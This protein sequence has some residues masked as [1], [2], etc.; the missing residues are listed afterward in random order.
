MIETFYL[1]FLVSFSNKNR[2]WAS[3]K[4]SSW[5]YLF[6]IF[7]VANQKGKSNNHLINQQ[8]FDISMWFF[9]IILS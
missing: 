2:K 7:I 8:F 3:V 6:I 4:N 1:Y 5:D 9:M